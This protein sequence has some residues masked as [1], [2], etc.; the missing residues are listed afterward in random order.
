MTETMGAIFIKLVVI[1]SL[2]AGVII[3]LIVWWTILFS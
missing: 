2:S 1:L 3:N